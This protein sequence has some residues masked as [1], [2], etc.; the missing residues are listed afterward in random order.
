MK[1]KDILNNLEE[2]ESNED[3]LN[4]LK[5][6][7]KE[8]KDKDLIEEI[9]EIINE[10]Q[11]DLETKLEEDVKITP[12]QKRQI[13]FDEAE[14]DIEIEQEE[15]TPR[16]R[17]VTRPI[18]NLPRTDNETEV[19][20]DASSNYQSR[21]VTP[22]YQ[23]TQSFSNYENISLQNQMNTKMVEEILI[24]ERDFNVGQVINDVQREEIRETIDRFIPSASFEKKIKAEQQVMYDMKFKNKDLKYITKLR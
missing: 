5:E 16:Q 14:H 17:Q 19:R 2:I 13:K 12:V 9:K 3:K 1:I 4:Y 18:I 15:I 21:N 22:I 11:E 20:Y 24:K 8:M 23:T 7:L 10:L 6:L